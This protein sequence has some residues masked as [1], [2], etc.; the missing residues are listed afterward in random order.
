MLDQKYFGLSLKIWILMAIIVAYYI[1]CNKKNSKED[2]SAEENTVKVF[3]FNTEWCGYSKQFQDTWDKFQ[4]RNKTKKNVEIKDVKC[5]NKK[6]YKMCEEY[7]V[8]GYPTVIFE[9]GSS[10]I[11]Y[12]GSRTVEGLEAKLKELL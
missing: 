4:V 5:D 2:F 7:Q 1:Y 6:N 10:K 12:Q 9:K 11:D 8:Q 3:N